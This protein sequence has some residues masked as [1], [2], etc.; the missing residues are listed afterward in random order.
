M[1]VYIA[2]GRS[3]RR[4]I[5]VA[6]AVAVVALVL[7]LIIGRATASGVD[8]AVSSSRRK[9]TDAATALARLPL[10]YQQA[11]ANSGETPA[12]V[13]GALAAARTQAHAAFQASPWL[14]A[15]DLQ[16]L[17]SRIDA[18]DATAKARA[19]QATFEQQIGDATATIA[20][21]FRISVA[22]LG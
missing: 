2:P 4:M 18:L 20:T 8:D 22:G 5:A 13:L 12:T 11:T 1:A 6:A 21:V 16:S 3:R 17:D 9:A 15:A 10:E 7:G 19:P 14:A